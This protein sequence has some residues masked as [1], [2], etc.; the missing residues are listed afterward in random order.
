MTKEYKVGDKIVQYLD[1]HY[2]L[3]EIKRITPKGMYRLTNGDLV[4]A[5]LKLKG[6]NRYSYREYEHPTAENLEK[7]EQTRKIKA[8]IRAITRFE[9][10][11]YKL[12]ERGNE[13]E[14]L[15][16]LY[17]TAKVFEQKLL[18]YVKDV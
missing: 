4:T 1:G 16:S 18:A 14:V 5:D 11:K 10:L 15:D 6:G 13:V 17:E 9:K 2:F 3:M 8:V 12:Y 7:V